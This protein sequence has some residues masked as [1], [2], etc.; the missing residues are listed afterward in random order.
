[1]MTV[2][3][4]TGTQK[5]LTAEHVI[6]INAGGTQVKQLCGHKLIPGL[7]ASFCSTCRIWWIDQKMTDQILNRRR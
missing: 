7:D 6:Y 1:M 3:M 2:V 5:V 4:K